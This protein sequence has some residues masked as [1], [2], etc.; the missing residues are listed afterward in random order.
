MKAL[1][2]VKKAPA[3]LQAMLDEAAALRRSGDHAGATQAEQEALRLSFRDPD[4]AAAAE[5]LNKRDVVSAERLL[6]PRLSRQAD[7]PVALRM[8]AAVARAY[9]QFGDA[10]RMLSRALE[11]APSYEPAR[12]ELS[13]VLTRLG[14]RPEALAEADILLRMR[15]D[16]P[17]Y[18]T[19]KA[20]ILDGMGRYDE[21]IGVYERLLPLAPE[22]YDLWI[23]YGDDLRAV[24]RLDDSIA[25]YRQAIGLRPETGGAWWSLAN[26][27][28]VPLG[29]EDIEAMEARVQRPEL[30]PEDRIGLRFALGKAFEDR[31]A[32]ERSFSHYEVGNRLRRADIEYD[33]T[34][35]TAL[36]RRT[37]ALFTPGFLAERTGQG[38]AAP[39]PIFIV[40][41]QRS[42]ST[43]VEQ[44]LASHSR[45]EGIDELP[46][47]PAMAKGLGAPSF[48]QASS[49]YPET[50]AGLTPDELRRLGSDYLERA[51]AHRR[52]DKPFFIDKLPNNWVHIGLISLILPNAKIV[53]VR[54]HPLDACFSNW[55]HLYR[56][57]QRFTYDLAEM[58][59]YYRDYVDLMRHYEEVLPG[60]VHRLIYE[61]LVGDTEGEVRRLLDHLGL[62][63]EPQCLRFF[64]NKRAVATPSSEQVRRPINRDG[65]ARWRPYEPW[66][67][68][69]KAALGPALTTYADTPSR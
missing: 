50:L 57:E 42:G 12:Q 24:G 20:N 1:Q 61:S 69:L 11:L 4:I 48:G 8:L 66:L 55:K 62:E 53:D 10:H 40:G 65:I 43:L 5:M 31:G 16:R 27:Q 37:E 17:D 34:Q 63:F 29:D 15:P 47:M 41:V 13:D 59:A 44:I 25:A 14:R 58:G 33:A 49:G 51:H 28:T 21:A 26:L 67:E 64:E 22:R 3:D 7:D 32:A 45:I 9:R 30:S 54:R 23:A 56:F 46:H 52:T 60:R 35:T 38:H 6:R 39:D 19:L 68:P 2:R 18:L 36:V